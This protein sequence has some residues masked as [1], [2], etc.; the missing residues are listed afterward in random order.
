MRATVRAKRQSGP[1]RQS[2]S[3][4][5]TGVFVTQGD[6]PTACLGRRFNGSVN[7]RLPASRSSNRNARIRSR[8]PFSGGGP[9]L[10]GDALGARYDFEHDGRRVIVSMPTENEV[11]VGFKESDEPYKPRVGKASVYLENP[12]VYEAV[13]VE[14]FEVAVEVETDGPL[15]QAQDETREA[16]VAAA[17]ERGRMLEE[18]FPTALSVAEEFIASARVGGAQPWLPSR[19]RGVRPNGLIYLRDP[20]ADRPVESWTSWN[21][22]MV[23]TSVGRHAEVHRPTLDRIMESVAAGNVPEAART[24][25]ADAKAALASRPTQ[26]A[27]KVERIDTARVVLLAAMACEVQRTRCAESH[28]RS[29]RGCSK[30]FSKTRGKSASQQHSLWTSR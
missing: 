14:T 28:L 24:L 26:F 9:L 4:L 25:L 15:P 19:A 29:F 1:M 21:R 23:I 17:V 7:T 12:R 20:Q 18:A 16:E 8:I 30:S 3:M 22:P 13:V 10:A 11:I 2:E 6:T 5:V 27:S